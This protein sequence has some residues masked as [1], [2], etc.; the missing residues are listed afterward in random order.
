MAAPKGNKF[1]ELRSKHGRDKLFTTPELL[2]EAACEYFD[3]CRDNPWNKADVIR[4]GDNA[5]QALSIPTARPFTLTALA[6]YFDASEAYWRKFK[7][8]CIKADNQDFVSV[9]TR[10]EQTIYTQKFEGAA[11]G[12]FNANIIARDLGLKEHTDIS[13]LGEKIE[14]QQPIIKL[15]NNAPPLSN[16][17][18]QVDSNKTP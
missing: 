7:S 17:E 18:D 4:G 15:Y 2:W 16:S 3:W 6:L 14:T 8:D 11:V 1:W 10:I 13:T 5:G 9:I 12:A